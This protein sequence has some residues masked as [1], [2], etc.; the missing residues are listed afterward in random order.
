MKDEEKKDFNAFCI[1]RSYDDLYYT[2]IH[3]FTHSLTH[4]NT[5]TGKIPRWI[6]EGIAV[7]FSGQL[8]YTSMRKGLISRLKKYKKINI[9]NSNISNKDVYFLGGAVISY[10][11]SLKPKLTLS[12]VKHLREDIV[13]EH[14]KTFFSNFNI[15][16]EL[17][18]ADIRTHYKLVK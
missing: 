11:E 14:A 9:C 15:K 5:N 10:L 16:C 17:N 3:E 8:E 18:I 13:F 6:W 4:I 1:T 12:L 7:S 2:L